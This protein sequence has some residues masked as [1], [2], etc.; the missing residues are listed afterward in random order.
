M[1]QIHFLG[2]VRCINYGIYYDPRYVIRTT[3]ALYFYPYTTN[4]VYYMCTV[5]SI[6]CI[7]CMCT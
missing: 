5:I 7:V 3:Q 4:L 2:K 1:T 6:V